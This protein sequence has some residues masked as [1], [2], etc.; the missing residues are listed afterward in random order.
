MHL[1]ALVILIGLLGTWIRQVLSI[2]SFFH[3]FLKLVHEPPLKRVFATIRLNK[4][5]SGKRNVARQLF[6]YLV[7]LWHLLLLFVDQR[8]RDGL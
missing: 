4:L 6:V 7:K 3:Q 5:T 8:I 2:E 1:L